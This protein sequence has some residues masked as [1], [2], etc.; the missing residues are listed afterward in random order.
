M[1]LLTE[2]MARPLDGG[3]AEAAARKRAGA[4]PPTGWSLA[5]LVVLAVILGITVTWG[6]KVLRTPAEADQRLRQK[7]EQRAEA[8]G[9]TLGELRAESQTLAAEVETLRGRVLALDDPSGAAR[10]RQLAA[11]VGALAV[12]GPGL[13]VAVSPDAQAVAEG[14]N[15]ARIRAGDLRL[16]VGALWAGGAEAVAVGGVRLISTTAIRDVGDQIQVAFEPLA[17]PD[18]VEAI[19]PSDQM[20][21]ALAAGAAGTRIS[22]LRGYLGAAVDI[23]PVDELVLPASP[24][25]VAL[26]A[27]GVQAGSGRGKE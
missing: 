8:A 10:A 1:T 17:R 4:P 25:A 11:A 2:V 3:Y 13:R 5:P 22:L 15:D 24:D 19:G 26:T 27:T 9:A 23:E 14:R 6:V 18:V 16:I 12:G 21:V 20:E 7:L